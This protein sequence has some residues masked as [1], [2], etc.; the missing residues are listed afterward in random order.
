[1]QKIQQKREIRY[2]K[3]LFPLRLRVACMA[4]DRDADSVSVSLATQCNAQR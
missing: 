3:G 1:M 2:A 4:R